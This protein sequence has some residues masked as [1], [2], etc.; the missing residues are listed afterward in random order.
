MGLGAGISPGDPKERPEIRG[1]KDHNLPH[2]DSP[3]PPH[4]IPTSVAAR[5]HEAR[6]E[7]MG[8]MQPWCREI[9]G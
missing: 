1:A 8:M 2:T 3:L 5:S 7:R 9:A 4:P 6:L